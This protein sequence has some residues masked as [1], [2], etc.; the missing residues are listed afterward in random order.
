MNSTDFGLLVTPRAPVLGQRRLRSSPHPS[1]LSSFAPKPAR[2]SSYYEGGSVTG[3]P[4]DHNE[5]VATWN[6]WVKAKRSAE[7]MLE[8]G[9]MDLEEIRALNEMKR[10]RRWAMTEGSEL[11]SPLRQW[12]DRMSAGH[13]LPESKPYDP[14]KASENEG[15]MSSMASMMMDPTTYIPGGAGALYGGAN[16]AAGMFGKGMPQFFGNA[17]A[18]PLYEE[19]SVGKGMPQYE[20][21]INESYKPQESL[22]DSFAK[23]PLAY[24]RFTGPAGMAAATIN[25]M[26]R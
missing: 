7:R 16:L 19:T 18:P 10:M 20:R 5:R 25:S 1:G 15:F 21:M 2:G 11:Q 9:R 8:R 23:N 12:R 22:V 13:E 6:D 24:L 4:V 3:G 26:V 14:K 17:H